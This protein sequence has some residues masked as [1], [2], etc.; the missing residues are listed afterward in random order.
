MSQPT[1]CVLDN[2]FVSIITAINAMDT[3]EYFFDYH[4]AP[5]DDGFDAN[6]LPNNGE[7]L[8]EIDPEDQIQNSQGGGNFD[9]DVSISLY[10]YTISNKK[11]YKTV[12]SKVDQDFKKL[13]G[14]NYFKLSCDMTKI[15]RVGFDRGYIKNP[16]RFG[17]AKVT[18]IINYKQDTE[19]PQVAQ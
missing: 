19:N 16:I 8:V 13:L 7:F 5:I 1:V 10:I 12:L 15:T 14:S 3:D 4:C 2:I 17:F 9:D 11:N 18:W 6:K